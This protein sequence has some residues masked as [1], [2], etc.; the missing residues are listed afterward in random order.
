[1][2]QYIFVI[3]GEEQNISKAYIN[4]SGLLNMQK[5]VHKISADI[6]VAV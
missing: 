5:F 1:M 2:I 3:L 6:I 4:T